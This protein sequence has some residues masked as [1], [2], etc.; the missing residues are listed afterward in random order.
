MS[1]QEVISAFKLLDYPLWIGL[2]DGTFVPCSTQ[3]TIDNCH[4]EFHAGHGLQR[5][6]PLTQIAR[7][8]QT[9]FG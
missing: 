2:E 8:A 4:L 3:A 5:V 7:V 6:I 9:P 1:K